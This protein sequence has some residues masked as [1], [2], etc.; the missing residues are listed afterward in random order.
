MTIPDDTNYAPLLP[1]S[2]TAGDHFNVKVCSNVQCHLDAAMIMAFAEGPAAT[3]Y[4]VATVS[5]GRAEIN[6]IDDAPSLVLCRPYDLKNAECASLISLPYK[7]GASNASTFVWEWLK[8]AERGKSP[9]IDGSNEPN[10]F[11][12]CAGGMYKHTRQLSWQQGPIAII[13]PGWSV[14]SK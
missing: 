8:Y 1:K 11:T 7:I 9:G 13:T 6:S 4:M 5:D 3:H 14:Y 12:V 10:A 2:F